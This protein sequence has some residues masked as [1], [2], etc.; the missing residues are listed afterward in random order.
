MADT[1]ISLASA[2]AVS[3]SKSMMSL[4]NA[5]AS[6]IIKVYRIWMLNSRITTLTGGI[7]LFEIQ[8]LT[9]R[10]GS[11]SAV[12]ATSKMDSAAAD[13]D[14]GV[15]VETAH[16]GLTAGNTIRRIMSSTDEVKLSSLGHSTIL[17]FPTFAILWDAG[18]GDT[19]VQPLTLRQNDG[20]HL[21]HTG[22][23]S[24][25]SMDVTFEFTQE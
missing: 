15:Y 17:S 25:G 2:V 16:A 12:T 3:A 22:A 7:S 9:D 13:L 11:G 24:A 19:Y 23:A 14:A 6:A 4:Y 20:V 10:S 5:S 1:Y 18:Y 21:K 8:M